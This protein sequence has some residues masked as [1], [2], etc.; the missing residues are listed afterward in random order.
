MNPHLA[1]ICWHQHCSMQDTP[2][3]KPAS[4]QHVSLLLQS[5]AALLSQLSPLSF[6][7]YWNQLVVFADWLIMIKLELIRTKTHTRTELAFFMHLWSFYSYFPSSSYFQYHHLQ[8]LVLYFCVFTRPD[9]LGISQGPEL[10]VAKY[11]VPA[12]SETLCFLLNSL[13]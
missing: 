1:P 4:S 13:S 11:H 12:L 6:P 7:N 10:Q 2:Q 9:C 5:P 8:R 3:C